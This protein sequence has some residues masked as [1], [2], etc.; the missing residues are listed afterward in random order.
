MLNRIIRYT[1]QGYEMEADPR[2]AEMIIESL[3][4]SEAKGVISPGE[5]PKKHEE[6]ENGR[7]LPVGLATT[8]RSIAARANYLPQDRPGIMFAAKEI[9]RHMASPTNGAWKSSK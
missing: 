6:E 4:L 9:C 8:F 2:H 7:E 5:A 1:E 3:G